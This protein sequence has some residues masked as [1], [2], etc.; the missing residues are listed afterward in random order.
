MA[1]TKVK[2]ASKKPAAPEA[3]N[4]AAAKAAKGK[5]EG[6]ATVAQPDP[7]MPGT[8]RATAKA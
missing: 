6:V 7:V 8:S 2:A 3:T 1:D 4:G 5:S